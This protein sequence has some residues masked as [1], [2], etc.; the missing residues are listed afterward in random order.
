MRYFTTILAWA[1]LAALPWKPASGE[2]VDRVVAFID[3]N[4]ITLSELESAFADARKV[5]PEITRHQV[6]NTMINRYLLLKET[7][8]L[9]LTAE[10]EATLLNEY[11]DLKIK[12]FIKIGEG[13]IR[14]FYEENKANFKGFDYY[15]VKDD[16]ERY[17]IEKEVNRR[18]KDHIEEL[19]SRS[20]VKVLLQPEIE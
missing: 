8:G 9:R 11:V 13:Q 2:L 4:A 6:L 15:D 19:R 18:L 7:S 17:L 20:Y 12:A 14:E 10:D 16:I 1:F 5:T 3:D